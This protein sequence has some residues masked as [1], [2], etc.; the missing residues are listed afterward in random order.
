M[1]QL[2]CI[3]EGDYKAL[4]VLLA[5]LERIGRPIRY[6]SYADLANQCTDLVDWPVEHDSLRKA[7]YRMKNTAK[8]AER[9]RNIALFSDF[10]RTCIFR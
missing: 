10:L 9:E 8:R 7:H 2:T 6:S 4:V 3:L 1:Y 5:A